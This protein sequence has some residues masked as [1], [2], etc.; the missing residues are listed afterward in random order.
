MGFTWG[1]IAFLYLDRAVSA[2]PQPERS[3]YGKGGS[4][5]GCGCWVECAVPTSSVAA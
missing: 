2:D 4:G 5:C 3:E 1:Y